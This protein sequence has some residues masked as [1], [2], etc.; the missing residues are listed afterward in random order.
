[1]GRTLAQWNDQVRHQLGDLG[2]QQRIDAHDIDLGIQAAFGEM[3]RDFPR[4]VT[5]TLPG[6]GSAFDFSLAATFVVGWSRIIEVEYPSGEREPVILDRQS[7]TALRG[8]A[9]LRL[10][11]DTPTATES[12][13][14]TYTAIW[15]MPNDT[16]ATD[17]TPDPWF[18]GVAALAAS[19][20]ARAKAAELARHQ[21]KQVAGEFVRAAGDAVGQLYS[22][23]DRLRAVY[24]NAVLGQSED[25]S[26]GPALI[27]SDTD[28]SVASVFHGGRR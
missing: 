19:H 25:D 4:E 3:S 26:H 7:W 8:A 22:L 14:V 10:L 13:K 9:T 20:A 17:L 2:H 16:A 11:F 12:V 1:M 21:S 18:S 6:D 23:A 5:E 27:I 28:I 15:A 24:R